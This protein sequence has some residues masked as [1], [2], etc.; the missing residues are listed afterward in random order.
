MCCITQLTVYN[1]THAVNNSNT[2]LQ[3]NTKGNNM[4]YYHGSEDE[5]EVGT[6][7]APREDYED[8]WGH[9]DF[10]RV[11]EQYRPANCLP[12][13]AAVFMCDNDED[14]D[15]AGGG[16]D[17]LFEVQ[18]QGSVSKH[19]M[20]WSSQISALISDGYG[21]DSDEVVQAAKNYWAGVPHDESEPLWEYLCKTAVVVA[22]EEY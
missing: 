3:T 13:C 2:V 9:N 21:L 14:V 11:L 10:Y 16:T 20:N 5:L 8:R 6:V 1:T 4:R 7:L 17:Y 19:D 15:A 22:V 12:H 18:P